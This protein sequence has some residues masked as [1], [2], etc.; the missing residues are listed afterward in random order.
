MYVY[1]LAEKL[2]NDG[3][4]DVLYRDLEKAF[5]TVPHIRLLRKLKNITC[6]QT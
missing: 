4:I 2:E 1:C 6:M 5:D 3:H